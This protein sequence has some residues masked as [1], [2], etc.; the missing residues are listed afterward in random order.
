V[1]LS[2]SRVN[3]LR[4]C[5][6]KYRLGYEL[7]LK[8]VPSWAQIGGTVFH[9]AIENYERERHGAEFDALTDPRRNW[10]L[11]LDEEAQRIIADS[12]WTLEDIRP[13]GRLVKSGITD[14][15]GPNKKDRDWWVQMLP[16][17]FQRYVNWS[18]ACPW[19]LWITP[20]G[21]PATEIAFEFEDA[22]GDTI[23][24][25][26]DQVWEDA[27]GN[28]IVVDAKTGQEPDSHGQLGVYRIGL[29]K[30]FDVEARYGAYYLAG[31]GSTTMIHDLSAYT[32]ERIDWEFGKA[33]ERIERRDFQPN[34]DRHCSWCDF[35]D[36]CVYKDGERVNE[37]PLP[38][39][40]TNP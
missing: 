40:S 1:K 6:E 22:N 4:T 16:S 34:V 2:Y 32:S 31:P 3:T 20:D 26:I 9:Q 15:G 24:G 38:W 35:K 10:G 37:V 5:G 14:A 28:L 30:K 11:A 36:F 17:M 39:P 25:Y 29:L 18:N 12:D 13:T 23:R 27:L 7:G 33:A 21:E 8:G 19:H